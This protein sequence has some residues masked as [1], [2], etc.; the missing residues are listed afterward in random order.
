MNN[1]QIIE[2]L[3]KAIKAK[4]Y[5]LIGHSIRESGIIKKFN[6]VVIKEC[7]TPLFRVRPQS[8]RE[9]YQWSNIDNF[10]YNK[11][12]KEGRCNLIGN[13][14]LYTAL[15]SKTA[16]Q[17]MIRKDHV[18]NNIWLSLWLPKKPIKC[19]V[20]LFDSSK[21]QDDYTKSMHQEIVD[22]LK[23]ADTDFEINLPLYQWISSQF[24]SEDYAFSSQ[25]C[26]EL[27]KT[28]DIDGIL[29]PS[30]AGKRYGLNLVLTQKFADYQLGLQDILSLKI[31]EWN[32]PFEVKYM[33]LEKSNIYENGNIV[34]S[35]LMSKNTAL[36]ITESC[37]R[38]ESKNK[39]T[40]R[41]QHNF[42]LKL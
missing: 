36:F 22:N 11:S 21:I 7:H 3:E 28:L 16:V 27:F 32:F 29:Y 12:P 23:K 10:S 19:F 33:V 31:D 26:F 37:L 4:D 13:V 41:F 6:Y 2:M 24:L 8:T 40:I 15:E 20:F 25:L 9:N 42:S 34:W 5:Q 1:A 35:H 14:L 39:R 38:E 18:G 17:E 30:Y